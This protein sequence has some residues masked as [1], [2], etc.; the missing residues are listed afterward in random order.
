MKRKQ[1]AVIGSAGPEEYPGKKPS[2][3]I[4]R[5]AFEIGSLLASRGAIVVCGGKGGI[6]ES[7]CMGAKEKEGTTVGVIAGNRRGN[8]TIL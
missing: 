6:M 3:E 8:Q 4:Y 5:C 1:I 7:V 2:M